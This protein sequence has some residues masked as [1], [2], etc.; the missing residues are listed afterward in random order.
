MSKPGHQAS[1]Y[2]P[3]IYHEAGHAVVARALGMRISQIVIRPDRGGFVRSPDED[4]VCPE[5]HAVVAAAGDAGQRLLDPASTSWSPASDDDVEE[6]RRVLPQTRFDSSN[7]VRRIA[8]RIL[9]RR[10]A[11]V[12]LLADAIEASFDGIDYRLDD[13][14]RTVPQLADDW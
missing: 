12:H 14:Y 3:F 10:I 4:T 13:P 1:Y 9:S 7:Q 8:R 11:E 2:A 5:Y 6:I